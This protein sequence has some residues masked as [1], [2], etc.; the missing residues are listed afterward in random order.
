MVGN[1]HAGQEANTC[2][3]QAVA[4]HVLVAKPA[5][6]SLAASGMLQGEVCNTELACPSGMAAV[7]LSTST[8]ALT[9]RE[10]VEFRR[11]QLSVLSDLIAVG[12]WGQK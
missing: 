6:L 3:E 10:T 2:R 11:S 1:I 12:Q 5:Y 8:Q 4:M 9:S 7:Q